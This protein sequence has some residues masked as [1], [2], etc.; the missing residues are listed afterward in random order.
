MSHH[1]DGAD[2]EALTY[3]VSFG[4]GDAA[5]RQA[6][7]LHALTGEEA[8]E[9]SAAGTLVLEGRT[10]ELASEGDTRIWAHRRLV[11]LSHD[12]YPGVS[13]V[14][15]GG[16]LVRIRSRHHDRFWWP[17]CR[18]GERPICLPAGASSL[19][20]FDDGVQSGTMPRVPLPLSPLTT[21]PCCGK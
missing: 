10:G 7:Q 11:L 17:R 15:I 8:C 3:R 2:F 6:L 13:G 14:F 1:L 21:G 12:F 5:G 18:H 19:K 16:L 4:D 9:D 20:Y